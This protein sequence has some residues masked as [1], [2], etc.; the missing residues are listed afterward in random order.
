MTLVR[1]VRGS[2]RE[3]K[4]PPD[5]L[6]R[7]LALG[8]PLVMGVLNVTPDSFSDGGRFLDP[9]SALEQASRM[10]AEGTDILDIGAESTRPYGGAVA[11]SSDE[12]IRRLTL[13]LPAAVAMG[14]PV[15][16]DTMKAAVAEWALAAGAAIVNDVWGLQRDSGLARVVAVHQVPVIVMHNRDAADPAIDI[17]ADISAFFSRSLEIA[18]RAGIAREKIVLDP[19]IGFGKTAEQSLTAIA[20]IGEFKSFGLP[21]LVGASRKRFIDKVS[22]APPD[23]RLGGSIAA[24]VLALLGGAAIIRTHDVAET[25]QA[26]RVAAAIRSA[27]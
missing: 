14:V 24:H 3:Q 7:L 8:R 13:V 20:R 25:V 16:I 1:P 4:Q 21:L 27:R 26:L 18:R 15:S 17:L 11:V 9:A 22:P 12:E 10:I 5:R 19:G 2:V 6:A 23:Q